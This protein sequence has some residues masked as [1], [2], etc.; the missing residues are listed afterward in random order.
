MMLEILRFTS[1]ILSINSI[2]RSSNHVILPHPRP[3]PLSKRSRI[4]CSLVPLVSYAPSPDELV[5]YAVVLFP[6]LDT[7]LNKSLA[8]VS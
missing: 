4:S 3:K 2:Q 5:P 6:D 1:G 7:P 8:P